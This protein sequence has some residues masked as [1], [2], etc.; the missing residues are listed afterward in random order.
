MRKGRG[1]WK[2]I[3]FGLLWVNGPVIPLIACIPIVL[4]I[5][6]TDIGVTGIRN[7][8]AAIM[9]VGAF[10][11]GFVAAWSWWALMA[12]RWRLWALERVRD[13]D[14]LLRQAVAV[15]ILWPEG[16]FFE[17]TEFRARNY[18]RRLAEVRRSEWDQ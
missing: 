13:Q 1:V 5:G 18:D 9:F 10:L 4:L 16:H 7:V 6:F 3:A 8:A 15:G 2:A 17:R 12:P 11:I 14:A